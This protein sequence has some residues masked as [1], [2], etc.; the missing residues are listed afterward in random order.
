MLLMYKP[1]IEVFC[2]VTLLMTASG[3]MANQHE[4]V[5]SSWYPPGVF[6]IPLFLGGFAGVI[7]IFLIAKSVWSKQL[8]R[9]ELLFASGLNI[10]F[11]MMFQQGVGWQNMDL[12]EG[13][14]YSTDIASIPQYQFIN[15]Q[16]D[17]V[18]KAYLVSAIPSSNVTVK[19][20]KG[21]V[22]LPLSAL[23]SRRI[24]RKATNVRGWL[25]TRYLVLS[26]DDIESI[27]IFQL[28]ARMPLSGYRSDVVI[29]SISDKLGSTK[30]DIRAS[31]L[32]NKRDFGLNNV[33]INVLTTDILNAAYSSSSTEE[34]SHS[35]L[36]LRA[37]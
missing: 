32:N 22:V 31:W 19:A 29:R 11:V 1:K 35:W 8:F 3:L 33:I 18:K 34:A 10:F 14:D 37:A 7:G 25:I 16:R 4:W 15:N 23:A 13:N 26:T 30:I 12:R 21:T 24:I 27:E 6:L 9:I 5:N 20:D 36:H 2:A 17:S 28:T